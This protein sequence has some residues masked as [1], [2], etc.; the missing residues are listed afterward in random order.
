MRALVRSCV[1]RTDRK[2]RS[3]LSLR[4]YT[5]SCLLYVRVVRRPLSI[6]LV[7][8]PLTEE[9]LAVVLPSDHRFASHEAINPHDIVG[10][11]FISVPNTARVLAAG[12][13][14]L[15]E[16]VRHRHQTGLRSGPSSDEASLVASTRGI[17]L[18]PVYAQ[19]VLPMSLVSRP[20]AGDV[21]TIDLGRIRRLRE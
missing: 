8:T 17:A 1:T 13:R 7:F 12:H 14:R 2:R 18:L 20:L 11:T 3:T 21:S 9:P 6:D 19:N 16:A 5:V 10:E 15:P 4:S